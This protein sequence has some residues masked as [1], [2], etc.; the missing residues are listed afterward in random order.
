MWMRLLATH[1][2]VLHVNTAFLG[3]AM[4][5]LVVFFNKT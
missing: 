2:L 4:I 1:G 5:I 3:G